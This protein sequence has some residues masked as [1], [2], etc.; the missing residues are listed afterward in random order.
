MLCVD[1]KFECNIP[2][3]LDL[4]CPLLKMSKQLAEVNKII[5][6]K[7][8]QSEAEEYIIKYNL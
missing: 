4:N 3:P 8:S 6:L 1:C 5:V 7:D 2:A